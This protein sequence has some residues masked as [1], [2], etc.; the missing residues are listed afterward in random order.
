MT[1]ARMQKNDFDSIHF[2][3]GDSIEFYKDWEK[4]VP[5]FIRA[6]GLIPRPCVGIKGI[7]G[8]VGFLLRTNDTSPLVVAFIHFH[9]CIGCGCLHVRR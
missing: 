3:C 4:C 2:Y 9:L 1:E 6:D 8:R 5:N 7:N